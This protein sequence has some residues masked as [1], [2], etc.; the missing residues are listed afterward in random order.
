MNYMK[1]K[2]IEQLNAA[3]SYI[4]RLIKT[5]ASKTAVDHNYYITC[6]RVW[7][8]NEIGLLTFNESYA[9]LDKIAAASCP[10]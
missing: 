1:Q 7:A 8:Y 2:A 4:E 6:G 3:L 5:G 9:W 10:I